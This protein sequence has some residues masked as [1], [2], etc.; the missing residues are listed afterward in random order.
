MRKK[1]HQLQWLQVLNQRYFLTEEERETYQKLQRGY[2]GE[3]RL[4]QMVDE[5]LAPEIKSLDDLTLQYKNSVVQIDKILIVGQTICL[6][7]MKY[8]QGDYVFKNNTWYIG[9]KILTNNIFE[10]IRRAARVLQNILNDNQIEMTVYGVLAFMNPNATINIVDE[11]YET[12]LMFDEIPG[13]LLKLTDNDKSEKQSVQSVIQ[14]YEIEPY[15]TTR[16]FDIEKIDQLRKGICCANCHHYHMT[17]H[18][19]KISCTCGYSE[20]KLIAYSRTIC[21]FG[22]LFHNQNL[23]FPELRKFFG[24]NVNERFLKA[25][26]QQNFVLQKSPHSKAGYLNKGLLFD[27]WFEDEKEKFQKIQ[28]RKNW[29]SDK[30]D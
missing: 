28:K 20:A 2:E 7:D 9:K 4:D 12:V 17:E 29:K 23:K 21:E 16:T 18:K 15:R 19:Y 10:Q 14:C 13:W 3:K 27:Y 22:V 5:F 24:E 8:Y 11:T 25:N 1:S 26:L 6:M 30:S